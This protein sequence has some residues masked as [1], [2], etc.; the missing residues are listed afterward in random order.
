M[1]LPIKKSNKIFIIDTMK[2]RRLSKTLLKTLN[3]S[4]TTTLCSQSMLRSIVIKICE[5]FNEITENF[6]KITKTFNTIT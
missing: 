1:T 5:I 2:Y 6:N 3:S 4:K